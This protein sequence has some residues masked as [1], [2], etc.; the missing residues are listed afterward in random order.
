MAKL[1]CTATCYMP[2]GKKPKKGRNPEVDRFEDVE[3]EDIFEVED[4]RVEEF[5]A[6]GNFIQ[7]SG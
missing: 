2:T 6:T 1:R 4:D 5:L 3:G 7:D